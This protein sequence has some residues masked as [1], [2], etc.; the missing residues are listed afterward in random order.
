MSGGASARTMYDRVVEMFKNPPT[1][2]INW[3]LI[4]IPSAVVV[5]EAV[6]TATK[7]EGSVAEKQELE[8]EKLKIE[9]EKEKRALSG[10]SEAVEPSAPPSEDTES[11]EPSAPPSEND[12]HSDSEDSK[13]SDEHSDNDS[14][15]SDEH[16]DNGSKPSD[17]EHSDSEDSKSSENESTPKT[18]KNPVKGTQIG[19]DQTGILFTKEEC[20]FF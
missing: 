15:P 20:S 12:E 10:P 13:P 4:P 17:D 8:N 3:N 14:K 5:N 7:I 11:V 18:P 19:G 9:I 1:F 16:S 6:Q 2:N